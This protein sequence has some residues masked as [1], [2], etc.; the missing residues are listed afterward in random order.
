MSPEQER[1]P[2]KDLKSVMKQ[3]LR[4]L[5]ENNSRLTEFLLQQIDGKEVAEISPEI[6]AALQFTEEFSHAARVLVEAR[7]EIVFSGD[8]E[9]PTSTEKDQA[10]DVGKKP[11]TFADLLR[12]RIDEA[13]PQGR[14]F[15]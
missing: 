12:K 8:Q 14:D 5:I 13:L 2:R 15:I 9:N 6:A 3:S 1:Q 4:S 10:V 7:G 11:T